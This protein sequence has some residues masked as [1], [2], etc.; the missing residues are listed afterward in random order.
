MISHMT[1]ML[2]S[3]ATTCM[4]PKMSNIISLTEHLRTGTFTGQKMYLTTIVGTIT[5]LLLQTRLTKNHLKNLIDQVI[6]TKKSR[7]VRK[8]LLV[9]R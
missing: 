8:L 7:K 6:K 1:S 3:T 2:P 9:R 5:W 4:A